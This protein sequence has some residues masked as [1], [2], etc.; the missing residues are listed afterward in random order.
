MCISTA[1]P[2]YN[3]FA[4]LKSGQHD[5]D[6]F[7]ENDNEGIDPVLQSVTTI[8][9]TC[10]P[11]D[12][13]EVNRLADKLKAD[14]SP[15]LSTMFLNIDGNS[16][17][18]NTLLIELKRLGQTFPV[19]GLAETNT[20]EPLKDLF[21]IPGYSSY[22]QN[23][24]KGK[25]KGTG[26]ALYI[27]NDLNSSNV[28]RV[29]FCTPD[30]ESFFIEISNTDSPLTVG[31]VYRPPSGDIEKF[32]ATM[33]NIILNLP[34]KNVHILGDFNIDLLKESSRDTELFEDFFLQNGYAPLISIYLPMNALTVGALV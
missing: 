32:L 13:E 18:F 14:K 3:P 24:L 16:S 20:D 28:D 23:T 6:K 34:N 21:T 17:N 22:Y 9:E 5:S 4:Y 7:H 30:I 31:V 12:S 25:S 11:Y 33:Q 2:R 8:L 1:T 29:G 10:H 19:I 27:R 15:T 26:V